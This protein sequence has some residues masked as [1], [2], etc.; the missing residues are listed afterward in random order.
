M[1]AQNLSLNT[2]QEKSRSEERVDPLNAGK[3]VD[4]L[5]KISEMIQPN[6]TLSTI[7]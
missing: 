1:T 7:S 5:I 2:F 4:S 3:M 6:F